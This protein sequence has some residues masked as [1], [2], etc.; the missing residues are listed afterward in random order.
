[1]MIRPS[2]SRMVAL[3]S[4]TFSFSRMLTSF[5]P[6][7]IA[8]RASR[9]HVGQ[10]ESVSRGHPS[11]GLVFSYDLRSGL[12]DQFGVNDGF[13]LIRFRPLNTYQAP[14]AAMDSPFSAYL[15][16]ACMFASLLCANQDRKS[17]RLNS[18]HRTISYAVFCLTKK[19]QE[20]QRT[21]PR[22][23]RKCHTTPK[24]G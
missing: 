13:C 8:C 15:M 9:T 11:G 18:S 6:S 4:P 3:I 1:M 24:P 16:G 20:N 12:S 23:R 7:R 17:T 2:R 19:K 22:R 14:L 21:T 10:S 5:L